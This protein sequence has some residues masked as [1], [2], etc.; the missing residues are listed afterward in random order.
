[1]SKK[2]Q[3]KCVGNSGAKKSNAGRT[4][5]AEN[6]SRIDPSC[7]AS[8]YA[9]FILLDTQTTIA[10]ATRNAFYAA[11]LC[12]LKSIGTFVKKLKKNWHIYQEAHV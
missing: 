6:V 4:F 3:K 7:A 8:S 1:M 10:A 5:R 2:F 12:R 9:L 11:K